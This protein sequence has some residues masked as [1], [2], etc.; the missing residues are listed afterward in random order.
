MSAVSCLE[1]NDLELQSKERHLLNG[2]R[3]DFSTRLRTSMPNRNIGGDSTLP[4]QD[5]MVRPEPAWPSIYALDDMTKDHS[6]IL[7]SD[8][9]RSASSSRS[10]AMEVPRL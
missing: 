5:P 4:V 2:S 9:G 6:W 10:F 8:A 7:G 3:S 1:F